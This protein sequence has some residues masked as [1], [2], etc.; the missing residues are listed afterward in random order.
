MVDPNTWTKYYWKK[1]HT[2]VDAIEL[3][4]EKLSIDKELY[5]PKGGLKDGFA[6]ALLIAKWG[7]LVPGGM[8]MTNLDRATIKELQGGITDIMKMVYGFAMKATDS[9]MT[10]EQVAFEVRNYFD[11]CGLIERAVDLM[12][13]TAYGDE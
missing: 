4:K 6:D 2:K 7:Q 9:G 8:E 10:K 5:G 13:Y 11:E 1:K 12:I 3:T